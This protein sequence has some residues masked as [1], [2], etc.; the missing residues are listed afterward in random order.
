[1]PQ[2]KWFRFGYGIVLVLL[3]IYLGSLV[4]WIFRPIVVFVQTLFAPVIIAG[5]L[6]YLFRPIVGLL[7]KKLNRGLSILILFLMIIGA[8]TAFSLI[9]G[10]ELQRQ[11]QSLYNNLPTLIN[12]VRDTFIALQSNELFNRF[13]ES[14]TFQPEEMISRFVN[15]LNDIIG[16][17]GANITGFIGALANFFIILVLVPFILFYLLK[18]GEKL[19]VQL[20]KLFN[21]K[22]QHEGR[23]ILADMDKMLSSYIQ[24]Q[25]IVSFCVGILCYIAYLIIGLDYALILALVAMFTNVIPF[26]GPWI[27]TF[28]AVIVA[29]IDSPLTALIVVIVV[30]V[31]QQI[32]SNLIS[33]Q[34]M[35]KKLAI[36]PI[37]IIFILLVAGRFAGVVG[38]LLAVPTYAVGKVIVTHSYRLWK[39]RKQPVE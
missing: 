11:F 13:Q 5:I 22:Q 32:E 31:I 34:V 7:S 19:P 29:F 27:G 20:L 8:F 36:H 14:E 12:Q 35:G 9:V 3:I 28:P 23:L 37:T 2:G 26:V 1:M 39:L 15:S 17:I 24:G 16:T 33:P 10:P 6:Y 18:E 30:V 38:M 21:K 25:I 4:D